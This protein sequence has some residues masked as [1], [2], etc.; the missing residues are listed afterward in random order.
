MVMLLFTRLFGATTLAG[1]ENESSVQ[2]CH[3]FGI[4]VIK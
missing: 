2:F 4:I 1:I 3:F